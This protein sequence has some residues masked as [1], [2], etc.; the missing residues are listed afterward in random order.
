MELVSGQSKLNLYDPSWV[1]HTKS[2]ERPP[3]KLG[4]QAGAHQSMICNGCI[5]RGQ[6]VRSVLSPGV[7]VSPGAVV[8]DSIL[9][10]D[11]GSVPVPW[12][13]AASS[14]KMSMVGPGTQ[15][16]WGD[17]LTTPNARYPDRFYTG[18]TI[19]GKG[20]ARPGLASDR[21]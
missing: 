19:V 21:P 16:G 5:V 8:R 1:I 17:D 14:T 10:N 7:H 15:L 9:M 11:A 18:P 20:R 3:A 6:V 4:P 13:I 2:E 12:W